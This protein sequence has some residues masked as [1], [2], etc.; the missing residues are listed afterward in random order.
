MEARSETDV[1]IVR[2]TWVGGCGVVGVF[3]CVV[4]SRVSK[5]VH[6]SMR[7]CSDTST[8][9]SYCSDEKVCGSQDQHREGGC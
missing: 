4:V 6:C 5:L 3:V 8:R 2:D 1:T 9:G 7:T